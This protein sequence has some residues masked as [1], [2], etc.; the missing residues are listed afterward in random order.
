MCMCHHEFVPL[1]HKIIKVLL[2]RR[3]NA[4][5][6]WLPR[7]LLRF[8]RSNRCISDIRGIHMSNQNPAH[9]LL[10]FISPTS[11]E[12]TTIAYWEINPLVRDDDTLSNNFPRI[13]NTISV[14][15]NDHRFKGKW[16]KF[17]WYNRR[18]ILINQRLGS[19][20]GR[21]RFPHLAE[22]RNDM[23]YQK[24]NHINLA[25]IV[26]IIINHSIIRVEITERNHRSK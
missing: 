23:S 3:F 5:S 20:T 22:N 2:S 11:C 21:G 13:S 17:P 4:V 12:S 9:T 24:T 18:M 14:S 19:E 25:K 1:E 6:I 10:E 15:S 26:C 8:V 7:D 16:M